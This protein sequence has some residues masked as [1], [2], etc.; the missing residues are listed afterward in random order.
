MILREQL[1]RV[2]KI[3]ETDILQAETIEGTW[4]YPYQF[5]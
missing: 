1:S 5:G 2:C 4:M 3:N